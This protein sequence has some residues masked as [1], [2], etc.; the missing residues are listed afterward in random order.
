MTMSVSRTSYSIDSIL[1]PKFAKLG[2]VWRKDNH[3]VEPD[4]TPI[5]RMVRFAR[6]KGDSAVLDWGLS[7]SF[8]PTPSG[9]RLVYHRTWQAARPDVFEFPHSYRQSFSG[10]ASFERIDCRD[11]FMDSSLVGYFSS[12]APELVNWFERVR[13][14]ESVER[15]LERQ[16][17]SA[18]WSYRVHHPSPRLVLAFVKAARGDRAGSMGLLEDALCD[19]ADEEQ[20]TRLRLALAKT[21]L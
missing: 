16:V 3:W 8:V 13:S 6:L 10:S 4:D 17:Q 15:E 7:L 1:S 14:I 20:A 11:G 2:L 19:S 5:R 18:D 9:S 12:V 21:K